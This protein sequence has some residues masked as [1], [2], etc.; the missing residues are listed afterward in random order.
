MQGMFCCCAFCVLQLYLGVFLWLA[1]LFVRSVSES[2]AGCGACCA[3]IPRL[4]A[5]LASGKVT[6]GPGAGLDHWRVERMC[7][8]GA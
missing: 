3:L 5:G 4:K 2:V 1:A 6:A 7:R 8:L